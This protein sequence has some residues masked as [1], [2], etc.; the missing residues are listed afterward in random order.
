MH[1]NSLSI[2]DAPSRVLHTDDGRHTAFAR[3]HGAMSHQP[4][5]LCHQAADRDEQGRP[6]GVGVGGD[7]DVAWFKIGP[8]YVQNDNATGP[9]S[10][11]HSN[12]RRQRL[13]FSS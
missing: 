5:H 7:E 4:S 12:S 2:H 1:A 10:T 8:R 3:D 13:S 6:T 11:P 9:D